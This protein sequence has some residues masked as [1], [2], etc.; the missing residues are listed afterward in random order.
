MDNHL[1]NVAAD[2]RYHD[3]N[4][5]DEEKGFIDDCVGDVSQVVGKV[6]HHRE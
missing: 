3:V 6:E 4:V 2:D 1:E 5:V